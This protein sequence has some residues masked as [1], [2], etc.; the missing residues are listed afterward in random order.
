MFF[1][2]FDR[3]GIWWPVGFFHLTGKADD[4][5]RKDRIG[6]TSPEP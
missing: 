6:I 5:F 2:G 4:N 1:E 3:Q